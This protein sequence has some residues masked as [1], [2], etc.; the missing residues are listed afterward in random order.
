MNWKTKDGKEIAIEALESSH[1]VNILKY[2]NGEE[3]SYHRGSMLDAVIIE[4]NKRGI[5]EVCQFDADYS[6]SEMYQMIHDDWGDRD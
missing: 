1:I 4:A 5:E 6:E 2:F 3:V